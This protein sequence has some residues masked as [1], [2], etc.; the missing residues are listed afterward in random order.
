MGFL[1]CTFIYAKIF[2]G[3]TADFVF[4]SRRILVERS[5]AVSVEIEETNWANNLIVLPACLASAAFFPNLAGY[6]VC[7]AFSIDLSHFKAHLR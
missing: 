6:P 5:G 7:G 2:L 4:G 1:G 3:Y